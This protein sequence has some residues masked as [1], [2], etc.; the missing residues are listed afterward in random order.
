M[1]KSVQR[2]ATN[3]SY[4][5]KEPSSSS[6]SIRSRAVSL[7]LACWLSMRFCPPPSRASARR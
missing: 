2:W 4:S 1:P 3:M 5:S 6:S 7:P